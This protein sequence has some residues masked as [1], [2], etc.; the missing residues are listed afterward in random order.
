MGGALGLDVL[1]PSQKPPAPPHRP[2]KNK[3]PPNSMSRNSAMSSSSSTACR[4]LESIKQPAGEEGEREREREREEGEVRV[5]GWGG[6]EIERIIV[7]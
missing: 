5:G 4:N 6:G 3:F 2:L 7:Q 1:I